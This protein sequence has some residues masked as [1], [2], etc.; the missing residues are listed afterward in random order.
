MVA[1]ETDGGSPH[2]WILKGDEGMGVWNFEP[3]APS[4]QPSSLAPSWSGVDESLPQTL[5]RDW[6]WWGEGNKCEGEGRAHRSGPGQGVRQ[7]LGLQNLLW[8][9]TMLAPPCLTLPLREAACRG[10]C[11]ASKSLLWGRGNGRQ[12]W[13]YERVLVF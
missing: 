9:L 5:N 4:P 7:E 3:S 12:V 2:I 10:P 11:W 6:G 8:L 13:A 1:M